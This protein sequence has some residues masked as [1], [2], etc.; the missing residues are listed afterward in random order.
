MDQELIAYLDQ[1][2][3]ESNEQ[4]A[5]L[6]EEMA[7][8]TSSLR[9]EMAQQTASVREEMTGLREETIQRTASLREEM[10]SFRVET[11]RRFDRTDEAIRHLHVEVEGVRGEVRLLAE[12][13]ASVEEK[14][15]SFRRQVAGD[16][17]G[18]RDL[19]RPAYSSL[20]DRLRLLE[21]WRERK[22]RDPMD[23]IR[24][25]FNL[26]KGPFSA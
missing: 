18:V 17:E 5:S 16:I 26:G 7:Q 12:G 19:V 25:R 24:E 3:R 1:R 23:V 15:S 14:M 20:D 21:N 9:E 8:Q 22:E 4:L 13:I 2:F 10:T 11:L 6:R